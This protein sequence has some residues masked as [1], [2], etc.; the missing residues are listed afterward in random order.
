MTE[1][2]SDWRR[3]Y[4]IKCN[5]LVMVPTAVP[6]VSV[7][8]CHTTGPHIRAGKDST[9][10]VRLQAQDGAKRAVAHAWRYMGHNLLHAM[11][12]GC[13]GGPLGSSHCEAPKRSMYVWG[14][15]FDGQ[16]DDP[17]K[18]SV[19]QKCLLIPEPKANLPANARNSMYKWACSSS[20]L[21]NSKRSPA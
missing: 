10:N 3:A 20:D 15:S 17:P 18:D 2:P 16:T 11:A 14:S 13:P 5:T 1:L 7:L 9:N 12:T 8:M 21:V 4:N 6:M 19:P